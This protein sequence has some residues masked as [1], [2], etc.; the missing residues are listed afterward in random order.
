MAE[1]KQFPGIT[2]T[3]L[4]AGSQPDAGVVQFCEDL[5][6]RAKSGR[7]Q[8]VA[9]ATVHN[10]GSTGDG[11]HMSEMGPGCAHTLMAA[12]VYL[13]NRCATSANASDTREEPVG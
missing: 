6:A 5:L 10:D 8:G 4:P 13:Q 7:V 11:W 3:T 1:I 2:D 9:A 12:I